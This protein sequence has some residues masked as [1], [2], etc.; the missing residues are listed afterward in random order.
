MEIEFAFAMPNIDALLES[1][2][3]EAFAQVNTDGNGQL[4][5]QEFRQFAAKCDPPIVCPYLFEIID[6]NHNET[7]SIEEFMAFAHSMTRIVANG[8]FEACL[9]LVFDS[10]DKG[11]KGKLTPEEFHTF[12]KY[13]GQPVGFFIRGQTLKIV[14]ADGNGTIDF[15]EIMEGV[16]IEKLTKYMGVTVTRTYRDRKSTR[17]NSSHS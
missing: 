12:M 16:D 3:R 10:C 4:T 5:K 13:V 8:D 6:T 14:D 1:L 2:Y 17:L 9:K 15:K 7:I 11:K